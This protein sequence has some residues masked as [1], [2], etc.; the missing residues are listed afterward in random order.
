METRNVDAYA[1][2]HRDQSYGTTAVR[3]RRYIEPWVQLAK[4]ATLLDYG[5]GQ[6]RFG[7]V[8]EAPSVLERHLFDPAI[9]DIATLTR[10]RYDYAICIDVLEHLEPDEV[11]PVLADVARL[12]DR[13]LFIVTTA[14]A[15]AILP[16]G[17]NA[18][19]TIRPGAWWGD[20]I[21]AAFGTAEAIPVWRKNRC[22]FKTYRSSPAEWAAFAVK[23]AEAQ[24][25]HHVAK[26]KRRG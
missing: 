18:H 2:M 7:A 26:A 12:T 25:R 15:Q 14:P 21:R 24:V 23:L 5:A 1:K 22:G 10:E 17:R 3:M 9:P 20:R 6:G 19:T 16:D 11:A 13:A 8:L 4:P